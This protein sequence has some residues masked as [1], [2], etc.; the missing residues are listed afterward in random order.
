[1]KADDD[2]EFTNAEIDAGV[3][4][5]IL[6]SFEDGSRLARTAPEE[7]ALKRLRQLVVRDNQANSSMV[8][9]T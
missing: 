1:M 3:R 9:V 4:Y 2:V 5:N 8:Q 7:Q 6:S